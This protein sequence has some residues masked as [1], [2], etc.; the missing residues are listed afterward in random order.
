MRLILSS[1]LLLVP[2]AASAAGEPA[3]I[4]QERTFQRASELVPWCREEAEA[5]YVGLGRD[6]YGWASSYS[7]RA[8]TLTVTGTL[9][10][11]GGE[12]AVTCRSARGARES[13]AA[14]D[15]DEARLD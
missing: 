14:I 7:D 1:L 12:V 13:Y 9:R 11:S 8:D 4:V 6:V 5:R 3:Q 15:F 2:L 10:V